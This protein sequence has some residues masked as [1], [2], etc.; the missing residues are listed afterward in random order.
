MGNEYDLWPKQ[1]LETVTIEKEKELKQSFARHESA[2]E[3]T[4]VEKGICKKFVTV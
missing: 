1:I 3:Q 4:W 2:E